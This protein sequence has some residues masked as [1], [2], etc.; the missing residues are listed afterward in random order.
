ML[1]RLVGPLEFAPAERRPTYVALASGVSSLALASAPLA[2]GQVVATL[3][4]GWLFVLCILFSLL[5]AAVLGL[6]PRPARSR[7]AAAPVELPLD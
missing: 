4:Y 3:G 1:A 7:P 2:A 6:N 5:S